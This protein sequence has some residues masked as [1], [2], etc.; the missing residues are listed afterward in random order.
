M[1]GP[2][3]ADR[4]S[5]RQADQDELDRHRDQRPEEGGGDAADR[6]DAPAK[7]PGFHHIRPGGARDPGLEVQ[8]RAAAQ[9]TGL[10]GFLGGA[11]YCFHKRPR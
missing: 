3:E 7:R 9:P 1:V 4:A 10:Q 5:A 2:R 11:G 8:R 6:P